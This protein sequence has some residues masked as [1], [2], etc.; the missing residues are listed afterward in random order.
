MYHNAHTKKTQ[1]AVVCVVLAM[2][3][4]PSIGF[5]LT[6]PKISITAFSLSQQGV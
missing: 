3:L 4:K 1:H 6:E 5:S 2:A